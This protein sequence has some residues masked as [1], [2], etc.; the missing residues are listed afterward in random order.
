MGSRN[1]R[2]AG[3]RAPRHPRCR[4]QHPAGVEGASAQGFPRDGEARRHCRAARGASRA[5]WLLR[6]GGTLSPALVTAD[7]RDPRAGGGCARGDRRVPASGRHGVRRGARGGRRSPLPHGRRARRGSDGLRHPHGAARGQDRRPRQSL[8]VGG[9]VDGDRRLRHRLLRGSHR[10]SGRGEQD[11]ARL[12]GRGPH[13]AGRARSGC[14]GRVHHDQR[15]P[16][17]G[18]RDR[19]RA[20]D[21]EGRTCRGVAVEARRHHRGDVHE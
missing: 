11:P 19:G 6:A 8:G 15:P 7:D 14:P 18:H 2:G 16:G 3:G 20:A 12:G 5:R 21:A 10:D 9:Q 17:P 4:C 13:R 1:S